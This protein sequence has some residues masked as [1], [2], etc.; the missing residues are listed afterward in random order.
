M[1][2]AMLLCTFCILL[3]SVFVFTAGAREAETGREGAEEGGQPS[4]A[5]AEQARGDAASLHV[6]CN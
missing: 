4:A 5:T 2:I 6:R 1:P 3:H